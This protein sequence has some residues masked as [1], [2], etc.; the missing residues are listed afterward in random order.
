MNALRDNESASG[1]GGGG[2]GGDSDEVVQGV[3]GVVAGE[4]DGSQRDL[5]DNSYIR[6]M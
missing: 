4:E 3:S 5:D 2:G 1:G 6:A